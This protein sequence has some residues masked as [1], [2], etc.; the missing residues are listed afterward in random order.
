MLSNHKEIIIELENEINRIGLK[1]VEFQLSKEGKHLC[2]NL[3]IFPEEFNFKNYYL[4]F[5]NKKHT[6]IKNRDLILSCLIYFELLNR[7]VI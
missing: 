5:R 4:R 3:L 1:R 7:S 2:D 6:D